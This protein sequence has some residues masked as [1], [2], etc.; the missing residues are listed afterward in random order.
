MCNTAFTTDAERNTHKEQTHRLYKCQI[1][2]EQFTEDQSYIDHIQNV[3]DGKDREYVICTV[4]GQTF[5]TA[6][7]LK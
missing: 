6:A 1:C 2:E 4:C 5:R 3:H 7:Q